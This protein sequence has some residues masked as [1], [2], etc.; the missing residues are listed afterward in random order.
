MLVTTII[1]FCAHGPDTTHH[2][3]AQAGFYL[4]SSP[5]R[6]RWNRATRPIWRNKSSLEQTEFNCKPSWWTE[7]CSCNFLVL[8]Q[9]N[10]G[11][12]DASCAG[13]ENPEKQSWVLE[14]VCWGIHECWVTDLSQILDSM[15]TRLTIVVD[16]HSLCFLHRLLQF[17]Q[18][19]GSS[20]YGD[21]R[22]IMNC[23]L[24][25]QVPGI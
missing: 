14:I 5:E 23:D 19:S 24:D 10:W 1:V 11:V 8:A 13:Q 4:I 17:C 15:T 20:F 22:S 16:S 21:K 18:D 6:R 7:S 9:D 25:S 2:S 12:L 3:K